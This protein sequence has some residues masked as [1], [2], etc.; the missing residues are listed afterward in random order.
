MMHRVSSASVAIRVQASAR[1]NA[2]VGIRDGIVLV[3]VTAPA[4]DGRANEAVRRLVAKRLGV[5]RSSVTI[6]RG[7]RS[8]DKVVEIDGLDQPTVLTAL[9]PSTRQEE[10]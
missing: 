8:R 9:S 7:H 3:R 6:V 2:I 10:Q 4:I 5:R 1:K